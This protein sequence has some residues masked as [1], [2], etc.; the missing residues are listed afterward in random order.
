MMS[1]QVEIE[2]LKQSE[3]LQTLK[4]LLIMHHNYRHQQLM[5]KL[6]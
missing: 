3:D 4:R 6:L 2:D 5:R 1:F